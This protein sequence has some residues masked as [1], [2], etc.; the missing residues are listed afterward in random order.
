MCHI[1]LSGCFIQTSLTVMVI[2]L[3]DVYM[4]FLNRYKEYIL[5]LL[6]ICGLVW[7]KL[8]EIGI[9]VSFLKVEEKVLLVDLMQR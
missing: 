6:G 4:F 1:K 2:F 5:S 9:S 7:I 8:I 3:Y